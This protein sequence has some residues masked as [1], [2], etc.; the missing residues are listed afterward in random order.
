M[1]CICGDLPET[2][3][4]RSVSI[5]RDSTHYKK[6]ERKTGE[7]MKLRKYVGGVTGCGEGVRD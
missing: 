5:L 1:H 6:E 3:P 4:V 2:K 7:N